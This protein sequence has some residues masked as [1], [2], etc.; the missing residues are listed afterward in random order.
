MA[1]GAAWLARPSFRVFAP[2]FSWSRPESS[3]WA[4]SRSRIRFWSSVVPPSTRSAPFCAPL[5]YPETAVLNDG[6]SS[7]LTG[8][9]VSSASGT[10]ASLT[11]AAQPNSAVAAPTGGNSVAVKLSFV[12]PLPSPA[13]F[14][15][16]E[17]TSANS[18]GSTVVS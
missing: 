17:V 8:N 18:G 13:L 7:G 11:S 6:L 10:I 12:P 16:A 1:P 4:P 15:S 3:F 9:A 5:W 2:A 14:A